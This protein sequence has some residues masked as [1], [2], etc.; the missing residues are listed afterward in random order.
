MNIVNTQQNNMTNNPLKGW[1][2]IQ[3]ISTY[4]ERMTQLNVLENFYSELNHTY[5][6]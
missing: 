3:E 1:E 2:N 5:I 4:V 6:G